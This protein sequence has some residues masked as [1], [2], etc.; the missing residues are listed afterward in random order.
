LKIRAELKIPFTGSDKLKIGYVNILKALNES[1]KG[2]KAKQTLESLSAEKA[3]IVETKRNELEKLRDELIKQ[4]SILS[5]DKKREKAQEFERK[6]RELKRTFS[7]F[8]DELQRKQIELTQDILKGIKEIV[9]QIGNSEAFLMILTD[10]S[11]PSTEGGGLLLYIDKK[12]DITDE[13]IKQ[14]NSKN[15]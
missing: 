10:T 2:K 3:K 4:A 1:E 9:N 12:I 6:E 14:Y 7:D 5:E 11:I 15:K 8:Q 13:V